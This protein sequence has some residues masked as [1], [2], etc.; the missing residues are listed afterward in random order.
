MRGELEFILKWGSSG[1]FHGRWE[2]SDVVG[3]GEEKNAGWGAPL[4][5]YNK[6]EVK[7]QSLISYWIDVRSTH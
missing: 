3:Q 4:T 2:W 6:Q 5:Y 1:L 7:V